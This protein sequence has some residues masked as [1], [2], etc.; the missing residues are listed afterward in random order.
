MKISDQPWNYNLSVACL[1]DIRKTYTKK[2]CKDDN[3]DDVP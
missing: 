1:C 3:K 2:L